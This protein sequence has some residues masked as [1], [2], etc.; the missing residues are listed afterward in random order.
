M[1]TLLDG[2]KQA[3]TSGCNRRLWPNPVHVFLSFSSAFSYI[4]FIIFIALPGAVIGSSLTSRIWYLRHPF[5]FLRRLSFFILLS[6]DFTKQKF[7]KL[8]D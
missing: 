5:P 6:Q 7:N 3:N 2:I 4:P 8:Q 1:L